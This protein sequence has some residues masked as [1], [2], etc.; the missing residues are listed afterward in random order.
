VG[1]EHV[2]QLA[3]GARDLVEGHAALGAVQ[4]QA[5]DHPTGLRTVLDV[6]QLEPRREHDGLCQL[7]DAL[8]DGRPL[9]CDVIPPKMKKWAAPTFRILP[10]PEY[11][12]V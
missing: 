2:T 1:V 6:D 7:P 8:G 11:R 3:C 5:E 10:E 12:R 9:H 4:Q